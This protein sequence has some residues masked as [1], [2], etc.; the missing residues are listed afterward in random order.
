MN[1]VRQF[2]RE[3][4]EYDSDG[5]GRIT[6]EEMSNLIRNR[7]G[8]DLEDEIPKHLLY[9]IPQGEDRIGFE[10]FLRWSIL[11]SWTEEMMMPSKAERNIRA[12]AREQEMP[13]PDVEKVKAMFDEFDTDGSGEIEEEEFR[14]I[15]YKMLHVRD[16]TDVPIKRLQRYWREVDID[17]SGSIGFDE[18][19]IWY[20][21]SF[22]K[23]GRLD[24]I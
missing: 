15:L 21:T 20:K 10:S 7:T 19:L 3:F 24:G 5:T 22:N 12:L 17:G 9:G 11:T 1:E 16:V 4:D 13:L 14:H 18:F 8:M 2:K 6:R 23:D